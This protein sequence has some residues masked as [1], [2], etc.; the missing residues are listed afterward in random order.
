MG[1]PAGYD[2]EIGKEQQPSNEDVDSN[3]PN[4][5]NQKLINLRVSSSIPRNSLGQT[6][7]YPSAKMFINALRKKGS[8]A[9]DPQQIKNIVIPIHNIVNEQCWSEICRWER[10]ANNVTNPQERI[11][12]VKFMGRPDALSPKAFILSYFLGRVKPFDRH[13][14]YV[15]VDGASAKR[16][17]IDFYQG[18]NVDGVPVSVFVDVRPAFSIERAYSYFKENVQIFSFFCKD[19]VEKIFSH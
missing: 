17:V 14:W 9:I 16:Y 5:A 4:S 8:T 7:T 11:I 12:L 1:C 19:K 10:I 18:R 6:W 3:A 15:S 2:N 13:D